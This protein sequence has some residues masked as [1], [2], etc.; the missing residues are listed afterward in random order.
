[1]DTD[2]NKQATQEIQ[3][4]NNGLFSIQ[5]LFIRI[6]VHSKLTYDITFFFYCR[7]KLL[8]LYTQDV[9]YMKNRGIQTP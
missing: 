9:W 8:G 4:K 5:G 6:R 3:I 7:A 2:Y 1:M